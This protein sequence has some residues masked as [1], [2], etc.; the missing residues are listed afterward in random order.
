MKPR[1]IPDVD[2]RDSIR[3]I[4]RLYQRNILLVS[5]CAL[6]LLDVLVKQHA[7]DLVEHCLQ[8]ALD[9]VLVELQ[10]EVTEWVENDFTITETWFIERPI[11]REEQQNCAE[12]MDVGY[13]GVVARLQEC[14][15]ELPPVAPKE[16]PPQAGREA[17]KIP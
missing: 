6:Q 14:G 8:V 13:R 11:T 3:R 15:K 2:V 5:E 16:Q 7:F 12:W 10:R 4:V 9:E 1:W 17:G